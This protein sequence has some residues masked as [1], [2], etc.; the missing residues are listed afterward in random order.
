M[1]FAVHPAKDP[2]GWLNELTE[3]RLPELAD[4]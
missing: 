4:L 2:V 3:R 1:R